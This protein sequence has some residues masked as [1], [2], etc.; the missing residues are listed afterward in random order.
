MVDKGS[1]SD[2]I[3]VHTAQAQ[4]LSMLQTAI[5]QDES[6]VEF[7]E[8]IENAF[9]PIAMRNRFER[10]ETR[11]RK[12]GKE[13]S[14]E[15]TEK[16]DET[17]I[18]IEAI[19]ETSQQFEEK[20]PELLAKSLLSLRSRISKTDSN[21]QILQTILESYP[22]LALADEA[23]DFLIQT[24]K[25]ELA[26]KLL[27]VKNQLN[28]AHG[29]EIKAGKNIM[30]AAQDY[31]KQN[32]GSPT[33]L[34]DLYRDLTGNPREPSTLFAELALN[35]TYEKMQTVIAFVLHALGHD[36]K[37]KGPS[38]E[39]G[40]LHRLL[41]EARSMQS[42]LGVYR[43]FQSRMGL[44]FS[45]F[46]KQNL[47]LP[48]RINFENLAKAFIKLVLERYPSSDKILQIGAQLGLQEEVIAEIIIFS[49]MKEAIRQVSTRLYRSEQH[50]Q[51]LL[52][53]FLD[54][55]EELEDKL[56]EE[57]EEEEESEK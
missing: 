26:E 8:S 38:I 31:S 7:Q 3:R 45:S 12:A 9:N 20:N 37:S 44:V 40:E 17:D 28:E 15:K 34:R 53:T 19:E 13:E 4:Q 14:T 23:L 46:D 1:S 10:L 48:D 47:A 6:A 25:P 50:R 21:E 55:L 42:I 41:T 16:T 51:D 32:L 27:Q 33:S 52:A 36:L 22:D 24:S 54:T 11:V 49:L 57:E 43:F 18:Q 5:A 35:Y 56:D 30:S 29:R 2:Q 39:K